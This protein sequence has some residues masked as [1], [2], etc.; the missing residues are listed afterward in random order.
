MFLLRIYP[1]SFSFLVATKRLYVRVVPSVRLSDGRMFRPSVT[2]HFSG[3]LE[4]TYAVY[5]NLGS[6]VGYWKAM[7][8]KMTGRE[9]ELDQLVRREREREREREK[10][11]VLLE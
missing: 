2:G 8:W 11:N 1:I 7:R 9:P 3:L 4:A 10:E 6:P 5:N